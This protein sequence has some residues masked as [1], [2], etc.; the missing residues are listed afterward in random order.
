MP[1]PTAA[2][3][4]AAIY[5]QRS[6]MAEATDVD[7]TVALLS[8]ATAESPVTFDVRGDDLLIN[9]TP[10]SLEAPGVAV[11]RHAMVDHQ[12]VHLAVPRALTAT[13]WRAVVE[14]FASAPGLYPSIDDLRDALRFS[15]P[16]AVVSSSVG[17]AAEGDL[18]QSLFELP[19]LRA[20][21]AGNEARV[22]DSRDAV[23]AKLSTALDPLLGA[24]ARARDNR[25]YAA[26]AQ[27]LL[28]IQEL[29]ADKD[30]E[31][32][33]IISRERRRVVPS[34]ILEAMARQIPKSGASSPIA[35]VLG[36]L[37]HDGAAAILDALSGAPGPQER[38]AYIDVLVA[39]R[40]CD[41]TIVEA[42][43]STRVEI[44]RD[45]AEVIGRKRM[46]HAVPLLAHLLKHTKVDV[47]TTAWHA[48]ELIGTREALKAL[49][50]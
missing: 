8:R 33:A 47:R 46:E 15:V 18:R 34:H 13:Q 14:L 29:A 16:D 3:F 1:G 40:D 22:V 37:G 10:L 4:G 36:T 49:R 28:Q 27:V 11:I 26:L 50:S 30:S 20:T 21:G 48:L 12:T 19:G 17:A 7:R 42:L 44:V 38:R 6:A 23:L 9:G 39:S 45:A 41:I 24:A 2:L 43:G 25:D 35:R 5:Q 32:Q 31:Q